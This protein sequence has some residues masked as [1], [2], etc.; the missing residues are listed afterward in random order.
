[1]SL[2]QALTCDEEKVNLIVSETISEY[3]KNA[4]QVER[5]GMLGYGK[6][7][8][9]FEGFIPLHTRIKYDNISIEDYGMETTDFIY[10]FVDFARK[11]KVNDP[12]FLIYL[13]EYYIN[14]YFGYNS[15]NSRVNIF[16]DISL[17]ESN[18]DD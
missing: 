12:T 5:L 10:E 2:K 8:E 14:N 1:M 6:S 18:T 4:N 13:L 11:N 7:S 3:D 15:N 9:V 16:N 17:K